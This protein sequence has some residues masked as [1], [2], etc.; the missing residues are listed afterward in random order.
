MQLQLQYLRLPSIQNTLDMQGRANFT[1]VDR[2]SSG[3]HVGPRAANFTE[4]DRMSSGLQ[5]NPEAENAQKT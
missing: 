5:R 1:V 4:E 2:G 3:L